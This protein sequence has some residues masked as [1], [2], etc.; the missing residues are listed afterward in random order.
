MDAGGELGELHAVGTVLRDD[1]GSRVGDEERERVVRR[2]VGRGE[3]LRGVGRRRR[4][5]CL[6]HQQAAGALVGD[7]R[8]PSA[9]IQEA[10]G[11]AVLGDAEPR[12]AGEQVATVPLNTGDTTLDLSG[13][14]VAAHQSLRVVFDLQ[15]ADGQATPRVQA[16]KVLF[17]SAVAPPPP[18]VLTL[19][20][21]PKTI[22]FGKAVTLSG[23]VTRSGV[24]V[25][26]QAVALGAQPIGAKVFSSLPA[27]T[28]DPAGNYRA[29]IKP[30][31]R[32]TYKAGFT[33]VSP[34]PTAVVAVKHS[35]TLRASRRSG[36]VYL[37]GTVGPR[38]PRRVVLIQRL[39]GKR[40]I[41]IARVRTSRKS[42]FQ[43][44]R[45]A[46]RTRTRFRARIGADSE[47]L[48]N[49]SRVVR[50]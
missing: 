21:S 47:H 32:T 7:G 37:R 14:A 23:T 11:H 15:S 28:T 38:H 41:T 42:T 49:T 30:T 9:T 19:A 1:G 36:K 43:L 3:H 29:V 25:A 26:G 44:V 17:D 33:G 45:K 12:P 27:A 6:Q 35:I 31:K 40:W 16:F 46:S 22:V 20:A 5:Q 18:P 8:V 10:G 4:S 48:G 34:E 13:V 50:A 39:K 24:P 2:R